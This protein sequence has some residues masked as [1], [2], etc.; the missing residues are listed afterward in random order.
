MRGVEWSVG[1]KNKEGKKEKKKAAPFGA[2][3]STGE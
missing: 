1:K 3:P 2:F